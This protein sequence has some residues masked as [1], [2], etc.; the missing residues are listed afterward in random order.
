M[1][2]KQNIFKA[3]DLTIGYPKKNGFI[4]VQK[5][6]NFDIDQGSFIAILG[7]NG[8]GK[9]TLL[10]TLISE[11]KPINGGITLFGKEVE[12]YTF[13]ELSSLISVVLTE[14]IPLNQLTVY[15]LVALGRQ[16]YTNWIDSL[17]EG[18]RSSIENALKVTETDSFADKKVYELSDGMKQ[19]VL[20]ARALAQDT[21]I[22]I[23]DEP[24]VHLDLY[25][26]VAIFELLKTLVSQFNKTVIISSHQLN[27]ALKFAS[28][29]IV[30][31]DDS[32]HFGERSALIDKK[33]FENLFPN[34]SVF[35]DS[36][37][38]QFVVR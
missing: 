26:T 18:D 19:R 11:I 28:S 27:L 31:T 37:I 7:K 3:I 21:P 2:G 9:S 36:K 23:L 16:P 34:K 20:I 6:I 33:C 1:E 15:E 38:E 17:T 8:I 13:K 22:M 32:V 10:K 30:M 5:S 35:F 14:A 25:H 24:T 4:T 29:F 12:N